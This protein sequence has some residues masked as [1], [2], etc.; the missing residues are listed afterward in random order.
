MNLSTSVTMLMGATATGGD[1]GAYLT[2]RTPGGKGGHWAGARLPAKRFVGSLPVGDGV[3]PGNL[4]DGR[5]VRGS[6]GRRV[7]SFEGLGLVL[8]GHSALSRSA[9]KRSRSEII[10]TPLTR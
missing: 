2:N 9:R 5:P 4:T 8:A 7:L 3:G 1:L 10:N 6:V